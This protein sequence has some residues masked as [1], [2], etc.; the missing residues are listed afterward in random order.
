M[1]ELYIQLK[2]ARITL[3]KAIKLSKSS[4]PFFSKVGYDRRAM[5]ITAWWS[6]MEDLHLCPQLP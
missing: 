6:R 4:D 2:D 1:T 5:G 3:A